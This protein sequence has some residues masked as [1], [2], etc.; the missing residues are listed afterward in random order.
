MAYEKA[1]QKLSF[2][3]RAECRP[4]IRCLLASNLTNDFSTT[5]QQVMQIFIDGIDLVTQWRQLV[6]RVAHRLALSEKMRLRLYL[7]AGFLAKKT[8]T[9]LAGA[10]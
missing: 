7:Y 1:P 9:P 4:P 5:H 8:L 6:R 10:T 3:G 2:A